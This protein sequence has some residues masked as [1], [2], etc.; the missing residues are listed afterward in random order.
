[1]YL[2][3]SDCGLKIKHVEV[4]IDTL[5][6]PVKEEYSLLAK[7]ALIVLIQFSTSYLCELAFS[8]LHN[9]KSKK[10]ELLCCIEK[11]IRVCL[12]DICP[13]IKTIAKKHQAHVSH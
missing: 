2:T 7:K 12:S 9:I 3:Y 6:I 13:N 8:T 4:P 11:E 1:M 10:R 5:W